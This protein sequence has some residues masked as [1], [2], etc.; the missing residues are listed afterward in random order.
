MAS[1]F[2]FFFFFFFFSF[3]SCVT[4]LHLARCKDTAT[5]KVRG[6][7]IGCE[8]GNVPPPRLG[9]LHHHCIVHGRAID[10]P[11]GEREVLHVCTVCLRLT[12]GSVF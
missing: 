8:D 2:F 9:L 12:R 1:F 11:R 6:A 7:N 5:A 3:F 4:I 10:P